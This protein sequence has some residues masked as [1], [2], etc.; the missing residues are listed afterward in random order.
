[1]AVREGDSFEESLGLE[2]WIRSTILMHDDRI[3]MNN[4]RVRS[5]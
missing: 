5:R 4:W 3:L 1:M 2:Q